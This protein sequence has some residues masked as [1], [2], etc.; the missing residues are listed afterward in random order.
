MQWQELDAERAAL[1][2]SQRELRRRH[3]KLVEDKAERDS[4]LEE[5]RARCRDV[6]LLKFGR[7][8][9]TSMLDTIGVRNHAADELKAALKQQVGAQQAGRA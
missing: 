9:D 5:Q 7:E 6:Q 2:A 8:I 1:H 3:A 4:H